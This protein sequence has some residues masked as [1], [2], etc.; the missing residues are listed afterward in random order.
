MDDR[1]FPVAGSRLW[2]NQPHEVTSA[3]MLPVFSRRLKTHLFQ[4]SFPPD[5][6]HFLPLASSGL[7]VLRD[8]WPL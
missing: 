8:I 4:L 6:R 1:A 2:K 3:L 5:Y 7:A